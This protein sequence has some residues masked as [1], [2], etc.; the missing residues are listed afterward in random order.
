MRPTVA[1]T[2]E[3]KARTYS[4]FWVKLKKR[5]IPAAFDTVD[6]SVLLNRLEKRYGVKGGRTQSVLING[7]MS[8]PRKLCGVP[9][10]FVLGPILFS[11]YTSPLGDIL[12]SHRV[13]F[14]FYADDSSIYLAFEPNY[15]P[16]QMD[17]V[18]QVENSIT[19]VRDW[20]LVNKLMINDS[21]TVFMVMGKR[22]H[23]NKLEFDS[24]KIR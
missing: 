22:P 13:D 11:V 10:G 20:M 7:T 9:Q 1:N 18:Q 19:E 24:I 4:A 12:L 8:S 3:Q 23:L 5:A 15:V 14:H 21:K 2:G 6:H 17:A 16:S